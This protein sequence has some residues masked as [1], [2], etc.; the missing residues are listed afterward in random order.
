MEEKNNDEMN[1]EKTYLKHFFTVNEI[2]EIYEMK[3]M[4]KE[5][6]EKGYW[7]EINKDRSKILLEYIKQME[8]AVFY[9]E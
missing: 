3:E 2:V 5:S 6:I 9:S 7:F 1:E 4:L 8:D